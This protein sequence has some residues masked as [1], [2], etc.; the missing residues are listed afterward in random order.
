MWSLKPKVL[1]GG[2]AALAVAALLVGIGTTHAHADGGAPGGPGDRPTW[3]PA[4]KDGFA[5]AKSTA[6]KVWYTLQNGALSEVYYPDLNTPSV[7]DLQFVV[8]DGKTFAEKETDSTTHT[9]MLADPQALVYK[10][11]NTEKSGRWRIT[12]TY[13]TDPVRATVMMSVDFQ[14]LTGKPYQVYALYNP[15]LTNGA[16]DKLD[17]SGRSKGDALTASD[18]KT[19]SALVASPASAR[20]RPATWAAATAGRTSAATTA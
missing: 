9:T 20:P 5:T 19:G 2:G 8:S 17:D 15:R 7:R 12:K 3:T 13:V 6:S 4:N 14:S 11:V 10:Q 1:S 16:S 18:S